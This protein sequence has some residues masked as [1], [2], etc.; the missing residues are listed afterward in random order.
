[1]SKKGQ[2]EAVV[3]QVEQ[4]LG[5]NFTKYT[6][7]AILVLT[8][9]Q[10]ENIKSNI[11]AGILQ[12][13]IEYGKDV[14]NVS[15][16]RTYARS[17]VMNHLKKAKELN[18]GHTYQSNSNTTANSSDNIVRSAS[19]SNLPRSVRSKVKIAPK[20]VNPDLLTD[21]LREFAKTLV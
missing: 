5:S 20:G 4:E 3:E 19:A 17:M 9:S 13:Q 21:D 7:N 10:L 15:E 18:G 8:S 16:V 14:N 6:T 1:M 11:T 2:K 12:G